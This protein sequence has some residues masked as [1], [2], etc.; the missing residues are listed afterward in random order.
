MMSMAWMVG[1]QRHEIAS[2]LFQGK[3]RLLDGI[4]KLADVR[5]RPIPEL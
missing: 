5:K 1:A 4:V 2:R 3:W